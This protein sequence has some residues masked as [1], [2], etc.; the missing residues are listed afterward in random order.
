MALTRSEI[1]ARLDAFFTTIKS[2]IVSSV[3]DKEI[4]LLG[5]LGDLRAARPS[6]PSRH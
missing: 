5:K 4:P 6:I 3:S 1:E 2:N